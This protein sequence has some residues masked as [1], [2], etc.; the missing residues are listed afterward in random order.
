MRCE[1]TIERAARPFV[2]GSMP[3]VVVLFLESFHSSCAVTAS[4]VS[5]MDE[6]ARKIGVNELRAP[7]I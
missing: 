6:V 5:F 4:L 7:N 1:P 2:I 3:H